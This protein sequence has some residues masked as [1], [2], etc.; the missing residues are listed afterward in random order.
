MGLFNYFGTGF[1]FYDPYDRRHRYEAIPE[2]TCEASSDAEKEE[3][4]QRAKVQSK[5]HKARTFHNPKK[6]DV[7]SLIQGFVNKSAEVR[8]QATPEVPG[9][10][11]LSKS[12]Y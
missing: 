1:T 4:Q 10:F 6:K 2:A 5:R 8:S 3:K 11:R 7:S 12:R 9:F